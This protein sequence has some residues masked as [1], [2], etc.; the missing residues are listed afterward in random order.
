MWTCCCLRETCLLPILSATQVGSVPTLS[1]E[2]VKKRI[3]KACIGCDDPTPSYFIPHRDSS[4]FSLY[5]VF[6]WLYILMKPPWNQH[7]GWLSAI[8]KDTHTSWWIL[9][10]SHWNIIFSSSI[11][12]SRTQ[13]PVFEVTSHTIRPCFL[14][15]P[16]CNPQLLLLRLTAQ[17]T[18]ER[19][20]KDFTPGCFA[21]LLLFCEFVLPRW[22]LLWEKHGKMR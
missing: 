5:S 12:V 2:W 21:C 8:S 19:R 18:K 14:V 13:S 20:G 16:H 11:P 15:D 10:K 3:P 6:W 22:T 9:I 17:G 7:V 1:W 4:D